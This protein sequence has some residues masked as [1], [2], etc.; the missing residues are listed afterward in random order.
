MSEV[1]KYMVELMV[2]LAW[3]AAVLLIFWGLREP[4][5]AFITR[6]TSVSLGSLALESK[7][8]GG[9]KIDINPED[10][11]NMIQTMF[12]ELDTLVRHMSSAEKELFWEI[13]ESKS[14]FVNCSFLRKRVQLLP[15]FEIQGRKEPYRWI[16][17]ATPVI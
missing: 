11:A 4:I 10:A 14:L 9:G 15:V 12:D 1:G 17:W 5:C 13:A 16:E 3:P 6:L 8:P 7:L 2:G